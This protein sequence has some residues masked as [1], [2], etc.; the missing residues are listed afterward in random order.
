LASTSELAVAMA[1]CEAKYLGIF[2]DQ[3]VEHT[4]GG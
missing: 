1:D 2:A 3:N 4:F